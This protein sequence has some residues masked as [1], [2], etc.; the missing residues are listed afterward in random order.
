[1]EIPIKKTL[2]GLDASKYP[3]RMGKAWRDEEVQQLL[4]S[5]QQK[6]SIEDIA[7]EHERTVGGIQS[8]LREL[9]A[10]YFNDKRPMK[11][12]MRFTGLTEEEIEDTVLRRSKPKLPKQSKPNVIMKAPER[13]IEETMEKGDMI[14]VLKDIQVKVALLLKHLT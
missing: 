9:A 5:I 10:A 13:V 1:M 11:D 4:N 8:R 12:I 3:S 14:A 2:Y 6:K 7:K